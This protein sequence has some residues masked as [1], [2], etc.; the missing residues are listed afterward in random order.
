VAPS[1]A[2]SVDAQAEVAAV[3][4]AASA[5]R[6]ALAKSVDAQ[7]RGQQDKIN[8]LKLEINAGNTRHRAE[9]TAAEQSFVAALAPKDR[10]YAAQIGAFRIT[11]EDIA[12]TPEGVK[13]LACLNA[14][15]A[16]PVSRSKRIIEANCRSRR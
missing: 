13:A 14:G 7:L 3:L 10:E 12:S 1:I 16:S 8:A 15:D 5:T 2:N 4:Y 9:M 6:A 11:V